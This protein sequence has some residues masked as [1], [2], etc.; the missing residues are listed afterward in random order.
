MKKSQDA[1]CLSLYEKIGDILT[2]SRGRD[3]IVAR[4]VIIHSK[5]KQ[6]IG[7]LKAYKLPDQKKLS[8]L[9]YK[10][11]YFNTFYTNKGKSGSEVYFPYLTT[12]KNNFYIK[13]GQGPFPTKIIQAYYSIAFYPQDNRNTCC[14]ICQGNAFI[15]RVT[16]QQLLHSKL[17]NRTKLFISFS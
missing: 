1:P 7:T 15:T 12:N 16:L 9:C 4:K 2:S 10:S 11:L 13:T 5:I 14:S 8:L 6:A 17:E 3:Q